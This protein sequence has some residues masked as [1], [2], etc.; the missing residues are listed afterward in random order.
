ME[1]SCQD[2]QYETIDEL[3]GGLRI[4]QQRKGYRFSIDALLLAD[5][6]TLGKGS[7]VVDLGTG[8]G[9]VSM[10]LA[11]RYESATIDGVEIQETLA[12]MARRS[13]AI[14]RLNDRITIHRGD[15]KRISTLFQPNSF[16][17]SVFNPP[18]RKLNS[19]KINPDRERAVARHEIK[20][21]LDEFLGASR[22]LLK[23]GG[24]VFS[25]Y[26]ASRGV[27]LIARMR[28]HRLEPKRLRMV[29]SD[30]SSEAEFMLVQGTKNGGEELE[31]CQPLYIYERQGVYSVEME[32]IF[33]GITRPRGYGD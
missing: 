16:D 6:V 17:V 25:I 28:R 18:Y 2:R 29:Y 8:S 4:I 22:Y 27:D 31:V 11:S 14:N 20:G 19:G 23:D 15:A 3:R 26:P 10:V 21:S 7:R 33:D 5:F 9:I 12:D 32:G 30:A 1:N 13:V 24:V